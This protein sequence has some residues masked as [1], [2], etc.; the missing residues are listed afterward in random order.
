LGESSCGW[1]FPINQILPESV[2]P[3]NIYLLFNI[4]SITA[5]QEESCVCLLRVGFDSITDLYILLTEAVHRR[6]WIEMKKYKNMKFSAYAQSNYNVWN[7]KK[8][9]VD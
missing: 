6:N 7:K 4:V 9:E 5:P 1:W 3:K 8:D 2:G